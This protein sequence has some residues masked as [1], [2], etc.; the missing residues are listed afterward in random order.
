MSVL[1]K[2][3]YYPESGLT[4]FDCNSFNFLCAELGVKLCKK[5]QPLLIWLVRWEGAK[6][7]VFESQIWFSLPF[8]DI[9]RLIAM[10]LSLGSESISYSFEPST[11]TKLRCCLRFPVSEKN[12][13]FLSVCFHSSTDI[14]LHVQKVGRKTKAFFRDLF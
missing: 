12:F 2:F 3:P 13:I 10:P 9:G 5:K 4:N 1:K 6:A 14:E 11:R 8:V 7:F